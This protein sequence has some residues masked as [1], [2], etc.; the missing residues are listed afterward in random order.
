MRLTILNQFYVP[1][2]APTGHLAASLAE[3]RAA[4]GD[5]VTVITSLGGY[6][7]EGESERRT[8]SENPRVHRVW[9]PRLGKGS[10]L[11]RILDYAA[12]YWVTAFRMLFMRRQDVVISMTT[13]PYI[14][15]TAAMHTLLRRR[16]KLVLWVM[17]V[18]PDV[19]ERFELIREGGLMSRLLR[20]LARRVLARTDYLICLDG[21]ML[22]L[23][24]GQYVKRG[25]SLPSTVIPNWERLDLFP[26]DLAPEPWPGTEQHDLEGRFVVLYLG[27]TGYGHRFE[28]VVEAAQRMRDEPVTFLFIGGGKRWNDITEMRERHGLD[29]VVQ[30]GYIPKEETPAAMGAVDC[31]LI[32]LNDQSLGVMSPSKLHSNLGMHLPVIYLG[33]EGSNVDEAISRFDCG[34][35][36]REEDADGVVNFVRRLR[37]D[38]EV[39]AGYRKRARH[40]FDEA[41]CDRQTLEQF[42]L[43]IRQVTER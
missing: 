39:A 26:A 17:D 10:A 37:E 30:H 31:A 2:L 42:D 32:T 12:F 25:R 4:R 8:Q 43:V 23:I 29:N 18:Y 1:D 13:P 20:W 41:Y 27:N 24:E 14:A 28:T 38:P 34:V 16:S 19:M 22:E 33:P 11:R 35:S 21:A 5:E 36:L 7:A 9:T 6:V 3:D 15:L 40:A